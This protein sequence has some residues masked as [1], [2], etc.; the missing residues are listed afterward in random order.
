[1]KQF[2]TSSKTAGS[3]KSI[4][5]AKKRIAGTT[6][7]LKSNL[8]VGAAIFNLKTQLLTTI[9]KQEELILSAK[10]AVD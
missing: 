5:F 8:G 2:L 1:M 3:L 6:S 7:I 4:F 9:W 10:I